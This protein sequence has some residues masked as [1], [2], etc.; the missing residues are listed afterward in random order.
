MSN[1]RY[2]VLGLAHVRS[3]WFREVSRWATSAVMPLDFVKCVSI[4][5]LRA[6]LRS[7]RAFSAVIADDG[8]AGID[9]DLIDAAREIGCA[10]ILIETGGPRRDA[11]NVGVSAVLPATFG[12]DELLATL[13]EH[14]VLIGAAVPESLAI[15]PPEA[16]AQAWRGRLIAVTGAGGTGTSLCSLALAQGLAA[17]IRTQGRVLLADLALDADQAMLHDARDIVPGV[18]EL[19][20][21]FR[22]GTPSTDEILGLTFGDA[23]PYRLLLGLRRHRD[24]TALR[25]RAWLAALDGLRRTF[26]Q[27]VADIDPDIEGERECGSVDVEERNLLARSVVEVAEVIVVTAQ[28]GPQGV[29]RL[30]RELAALLEHGVRPER[31]LPV[32]NRA[33]RP[34][35]ARAEIARTIAALTEPLGSRSSALASPLF[36]PDLRRIDTNLRDGASVPASFATSLADA[37]NAIATRAAVLPAAHRDEE[38]LAI[39]PGSL[40]SWST[41]QEAAG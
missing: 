32:L 7:G 12:R 23:H 15:N 13:D 21:A 8:L 10:T 28:P 29:H 17:D 35:R 25:P 37:V 3:A 2:V 18:Q 11:V 19:V 31:I 40:G 24:W 22:H 36:V 14:A 6:R 38:P 41:S 20:D 9:R 30:V 5:E 1:E 27:I 34:P 4:D 16:P 39:V 33:P 26:T